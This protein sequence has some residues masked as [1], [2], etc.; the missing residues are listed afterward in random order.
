[1]PADA[2]AASIPYSTIADPLDQSRIEDALADG[3]GD[4]SAGE[5]RAAELEHA[6]TRMAPR[7]VRAPDPTLVPIALATSLAP[8]AQAM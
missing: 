4:V 8:I 1:M 5:K 3:V 7:I 6:A 2:S